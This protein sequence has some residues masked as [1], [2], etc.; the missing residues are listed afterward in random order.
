MLHS[1]YRTY[2]MNAKQNMASLVRQLDGNDM[3]KGN[4]HNGENFNT[5]L[6]IDP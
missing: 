6:Y 2:L 5:V 3:L 4:Y 1:G